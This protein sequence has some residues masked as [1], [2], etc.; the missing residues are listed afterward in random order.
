MIDGRSFEFERQP[1]SGVRVENISKQPRS[2]T[3]SLSRSLIHFVSDLLASHAGQRHWSTELL[4]AR[5]RLFV[6]TT[7]ALWST[8]VARQSVAH[9]WESVHCGT[10]EW[11]WRKISHEL[12]SQ[13]ISRASRWIG[14]LLRASTVS[15]FVGGVRGR[16]KNLTIARVRAYKCMCVCAHSHKW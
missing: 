9:R 4:V 10:E 1:M 11:S 13:T 16:L 5:L 12:Q 6:V 3:C 2:M 8:L 15:V 14:S 7:S